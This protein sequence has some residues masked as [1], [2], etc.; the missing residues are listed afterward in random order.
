MKN[1][2]ALLG[3]SYRTWRALRRFPGVFSLGD[4]SKRLRHVVQPNRVTE[5]ELRRW[6]EKGLTIKNGSKG[7]YE[8]EVRGT[9]LMFYWLGSV[10]GGLA[11]GVLQEVDPTHPHYY[12]TPPVQM[13]PSSLVLDVGSCE[14]L[15]AFRLLK[16]REAAKV[17]CFEPSARTASF[18]QRAAEKNGVSANLQV[19]ICAVGRTSGEVNFIDSDVPEANRVVTHSS[20][21]STRVPQ[22]SLDDY[23]KQKNIRLGAADLIKVDAE[24]ADVEVIKGAECLIQEGSPQIAVT[25]YHHPEHAAELI[26]FLRSIQP[27][28]QLR[29]K[30][31][32]LFNN[33]SLPRPVLLQAALPRPAA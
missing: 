14:G 9:G 23:C 10:C 31:F 24:G 4:A 27:R 20:P 11:N 16:N 13:R 30:G 22:V 7:I 18:L 12:T 1:P 25:T 32:V 21:G 8:I 5:W 3:H 19:E 33:S 28:Y 6:I 29:L 15:F 2:V 17:V 26:G